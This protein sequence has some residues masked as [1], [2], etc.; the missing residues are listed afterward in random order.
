M[1]RNVLLRQILGAPML[2][3]NTTGRLS[4][5]AAAP[6]KV[7]TP[8]LA[9]THAHPRPAQ[10]SDYLQRTRRLWEAASESAGHR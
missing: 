6:Q 3:L 10:E 1:A 7:G 9:A 8:S 4:D 5:T 2:G